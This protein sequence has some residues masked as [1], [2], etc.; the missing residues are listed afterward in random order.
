MSSPI[1]LFFFS[2]LV[3]NVISFLS[4]GRSLAIL[5]TLT[6][7]VWMKRAGGGQGVGRGT[8]GRMA[9]LIALTEGRV[10]QACTTAHQKT[11]MMKSKFGLKSKEKRAIST[12]NTANTSTNTLRKKSLSMASGC[13]P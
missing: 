2:K 5:S 4:K 13:I 8:D 9:I 12:N 7:I 10:L 3:S 1:P 11:R 6:T